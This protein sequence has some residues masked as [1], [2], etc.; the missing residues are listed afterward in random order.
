M[1]RRSL[2]AAGLL[3]VFG[4]VAANPEGATATPSSPHFIQGRAQIDSGTSL[5]VGYSNTVQAGS[6]LVGVFRTAS[7]TA[8]SDNVN[9][10]WVRAASSGVNSL[11]YLPNAKAGATTVTVTG[12]MSGPVRA[13][14][15]EYSGVATSAPLDGSSCNETGF[16]TASTTGSTVPVEAGELAFIGFGSYANPIAVESMSSAGVAGALRNQLTGSLGTVA[17]GDVVPTASG[18][19]EGRVSLSGSADSAA[20]VAVFRSAGSASV[21]PAPTPALW[22][23]DFEAGNLSQWS[24]NQS[25]SEGVTVVNSP[26]RSGQY[27]AKFTVT[28]T[29]TSE[30]CP[31]VPTSS[32]RAQLVGPQMFTEGSDDYIGFSTFFPADFPTISSGW[33]QV[34]EIYG[35]PFGGSPSIGID[36]VG[37]RLALQ[38]DP[39]HNWDT[40]WT[41]PTEISKGTAWEDIVLHVKFSTDPSVGF[42]E[43]WLNGAQ[44]TFKNGARR[45]YY[46]T[47]VPGV[48]WDG[49]SPNRVYLNQYRSSSPPR[50]AVTLYHDAARVGTSYASVAP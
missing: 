45:I 21:A 42:V 27:A 23:G 30:Y 38:R 15:A 32:P 12:T 33:M 34:A 48:N 28:D 19:Q 8:V 6:L 44:Q 39:T 46:D 36:V 37:N 1:R 49:S 9:G 47:L 11:W 4:L 7:G 14:I 24:L 26:V 25:C 35:P 22:S 10:P 13:G 3:V 40:I 31:L 16:G 50:G 17:D 41:S 2:L 18:A 29:S 20:C 5:S 43:L